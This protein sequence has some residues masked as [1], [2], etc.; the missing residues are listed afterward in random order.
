M[1]PVGLHWTRLARFIRGP[2]IDGAIASD[3]G[4]VLAFVAQVEVFITHQSGSR[5]SIERELQRRLGPLLASR[6]ALH[7][8]PLVLMVFSTLPSI[9]AAVDATTMARLN[10]LL[11]STDKVRPLLRLYAGMIAAL[12]PWLGRRL[13][14]KA[15]K[16]G[17]KMRLQASRA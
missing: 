14:M 8:A 2:G 4:K 16:F 10:A 6:H 1:A 15:P 7:W 12:Y 11:T 13:L 9:K 5:P 17:P 3:V